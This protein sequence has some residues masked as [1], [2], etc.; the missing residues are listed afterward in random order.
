MRALFLVL[1]VS[2]T[3]CYV[4]TPDTCADG[5]CSASGACIVSPIEHNAC[6]LGGGA[7]MDCTAQGMECVNSQCVGK[8][9]AATC[10]GCCLGTQCVQTANQSSMRCGLNGATCTVCARGCTA[11]VCQ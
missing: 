3:G 4:C 7:C 5:C 9:S 8:C 2:L 11:G 6:G 1:F 10:A